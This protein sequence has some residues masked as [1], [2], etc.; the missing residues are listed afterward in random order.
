MRLSTGK[1]I[2][3]WNITKTGVMDNRGQMGLP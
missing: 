2:I 3:I 1:W